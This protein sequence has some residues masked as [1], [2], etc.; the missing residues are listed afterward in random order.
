[1]DFDVVNVISYKVTREDFCNKLTSQNA[2]QEGH[3]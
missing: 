1:M 3:G 2:C